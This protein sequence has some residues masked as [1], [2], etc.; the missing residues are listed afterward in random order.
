MINFDDLKTL[1]IE[2][3]LR[4]LNTSIQ[5]IEN[6][7]K[8]ESVND[9]ELLESLKASLLLKG[10]YKPIKIKRLWLMDLAKKLACV[11]L[12]VDLS[13]NENLKSEFK[14]T[15]ERL[16]DGH[17]VAIFKYYEKKYHELSKI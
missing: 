1:A 13:K 7:D 11:H 16:N 15:I 5:K 12:L 3:L 4:E 9:K 14:N 17:G 6:L 8:S 10:I 2:I